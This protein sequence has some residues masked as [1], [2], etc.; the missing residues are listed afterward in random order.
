MTGTR[1]DRPQLEE[2]LKVLRSGDK[3]VLYKLGRISCYTKH[4]NELSEVFNDSEV[5]FVSI[6]DSID[7]SN[8]MGKFCFSTMRILQN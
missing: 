5:D 3:V 8:A 4:L 7:T 2:P 1:K 6:T